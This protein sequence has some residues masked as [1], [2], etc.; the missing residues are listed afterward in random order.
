[1]LRSPAN[2]CMRY[3]GCLCLCPTGRR[4]E[5]RAVWGLDDQSGAP[6]LPLPGFPGPSTPVP[7][8]QPRFTSPLQHV[9]LSPEL[10]SASLPTNTS[11]AASAP[12]CCH[13]CAARFQNRFV[14]GLEKTHFCVLSTGFHRYVKE[15]GLNACSLSC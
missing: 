7:R 10:C 4:A 12:R 13:C 8:E 1:M 5:V 15:K 3:R 11:A 2:G 14:P 6:Q 9:S